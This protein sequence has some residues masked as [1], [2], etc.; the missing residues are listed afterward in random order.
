MYSVI[1]PTYKRRDDLFKCLSCLSEYFS[2]PGSADAL[3]GVEV[4]ISD[5][6]RESTLRDALATRFP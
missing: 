5:D 6:A 3:S 4:I 1:I 2:S